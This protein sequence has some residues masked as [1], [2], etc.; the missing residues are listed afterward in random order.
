MA[1]TLVEPVVF[2]SVAIV[3]DSNRLLQRKLKRTGTEWSLGVKKIKSRSVDVK[4]VGI[5][6]RSAEKKLT[7]TRSFSVLG[8][9]ETAEGAMQRKKILLVRKQ[10]GPPIGTEAKNGPLSVAQAQHFSHLPWR[11]QPRWLWLFL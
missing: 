2:A 1:S 11:H 10:S 8:A 3:S 7:E 4:W 6:K 5:R 9:T